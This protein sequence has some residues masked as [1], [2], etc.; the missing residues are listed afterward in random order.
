MIL[1]GRSLCL[2]S[3][4]TVQGLFSVARDASIIPDISL[5]PVLTTFLSLDSSAALQHQYAFLQRSMSR[6]Q[7]AK[8]SLSLTG[9]LGGSSRVTYGGVGVVAL[10]LS[11]LF[12]Q[13]AQQVRTQRSTEGDLSTQRSQ[14]KRIFGISSS[15]KIGWLIHNYLSLVPGIANNQEKMAETTEL[16]DS[17]LKLELIDHYERMTTK[18]RMSSVSMQQ[19]VTGA[20]FHLHMRIH[21]VRLH[22]V[23][24]GTAESLRLSYKTGLSRLVQGY[25]AYLRRNIQET[26][27]PGPRKPKT[28]TASG[29]RQTNTSSVTNMACSSNSVLNVSQV[30]P[31]SISTDRFNETIAPNSTAKMGRSCKTSGSREDFGVNVL[32]ASDETAVGM[33]NSNSTGFS[34]EED[35]GMLGLLVIESWS[36]VSHNVQHHPCESP[37]IQEALVTRIINAQDLERNRNFFLYP[38]KVFHSLLRQKNDFEL[39]TN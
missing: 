32:K 15:S 26:A 20:A 34:R 17:W 3:P 13:V 35:V 11:M 38:E 9:E 2:P 23:P 21:Q 14:A 28:R 36:N 25:T 37:A 5:D 16:Y 18:K 8:F 24:L 12:D 30:S 33:V 10:A 6:E 4:A 27:A 7:Q 31:A 39:K 29:P 1:M 22:S 19:W